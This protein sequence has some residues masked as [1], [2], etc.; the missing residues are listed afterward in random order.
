[1]ED[2]ATSPQLSLNEIQRILREKMTHFEDCYSVRTLEIFGSFVRAEASEHS[3]ID[4]L[5]EFSKAP[6]LFSFIRLEDELS[7]LLGV[8]VDLVM[9]SSL[10]PS[11]GAR[12]LSESVAV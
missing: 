6:T 12:I 11:I 3:D 2:P 8:K 1:M 9:K 5:V 10:K 7:N 4:V